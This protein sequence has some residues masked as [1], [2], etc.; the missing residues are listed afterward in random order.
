M[1]FHG[2]VGERFSMSRDHARASAA[3]MGNIRM[4]QWACPWREPWRRSASVDLT[5]H[6]SAAIIAICS[7]IPRARTDVRA[8]I[9]MCDR[10]GFE[11]RRRRSNRRPAARQEGG[12]EA[13]PARR[14]G[15]P[16]RT[17]APTGPACDPNSERQHARLRSLLKH[18]TRGEIAVH[19][20]ALVIPATERRERAA[21]GRWRANAPTSTSAGS[22]RFVLMP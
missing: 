1:S 13:K 9:P 18:F 15:P 19:G 8:S 16:P 22:G 14:R 11:R 12:G 6:T 17:A 4:S 10:A 5:N 7:A 2:N 20:R 3:G 21:N